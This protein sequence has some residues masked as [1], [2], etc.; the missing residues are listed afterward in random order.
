MAADKAC[1]IKTL[2]PSGMF[3]E[4]VGKAYIYQQ[5]WTVVTK[6]ENTGLTSTL[7]FVE[8]CK[9]SMNT[10]C[11]TRES[12]VGDGECHHWESDINFLVKQ[13]KV[14]NEELDF[15][16]KKQTC[17]RNRRGLFNF[18]GWVLNKVFGTMD[19]E[20]AEG[21]YNRLNS[22]EK[23]DKEHIDMMQKQITLIK[24]NFNELSKPIQEME[25]EQNRMAAKLNDFVKYVEENMESLKKDSKDLH[26]QAKIND[27][28]TYILMRLNAIFQ[29]QTDYFAIINSINSNKL[30]PLILN[31]SDISTISQRISN[32]LTKGSRTLDYH[33]LKQ[34]IRMETYHLD[35]ALL[36]K[37]KIPLPE[38]D[39]F[40]ISK[41]YV[42]PQKVAVNQYSIIDTKVSY[43]FNSST[44]DEIV[45][46]ESNE[47]RN[48]CDKITVFQGEKIYLCYHVQARHLGPEIKSCLLTNDLNLSNDGNLT[49][50]CPYKILSG[51]QEV[52]VKLESKNG[53]FFLFE[54]ERVLQSTCGKETE[55]IKLLGQGIII[56]NQACTF[57][58]GSLLLPFEYDMEEKLSISQPPE[59]EKF[60]PVVKAEYLQHLNRFQTN[61]S[62][63][64]IVG[65]S[66][67]NEIFDRESKSI[68]DLEKEISET[69]IQRR[70][71][72]YEMYH[73]ISYGLIGG[74]LLVL[75]IFILFVLLM[76]KRK[77][78]STPVAKITRPKLEISQPIINKLPHVSPPVKEE[79]YEEPIRVEDKSN[80]TCRVRITEDSAAFSPSTFTRDNIRLTIPKIGIFKV[81]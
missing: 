69:K 72:Q 11:S 78:K 40:N 17:S 2:E 37:I 30:H 36:M 76:K 25:K 63:L 59:F 9:E 20:E 64:T 74:I 73:K 31:P 65:H 71:E 38:R 42:L 80:K 62:A 48:K 67:Y 26:L 79:I 39:E 47:F 55:Q 41:V 3:L 43:I 35:G 33:L 81:K 10:L 34:M 28:A 58:L 6:L 29:R 44:G 32:Y 77:Y 1:E 19:T 21:I 8:S 50:P 18:G 66:K 75:I 13:I 60:N 15:F 4:H 46:L 22:L 56:L 49:I 53:W 68:L 70:H 12:L 27:I 14:R 52:L 16:F 45:K 7:K 23:H 51:K 5:S 54:D 61:D 24:S 57:T